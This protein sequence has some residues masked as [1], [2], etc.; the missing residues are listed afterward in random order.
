MVKKLFVLL[1]A[2][3]APELEDHVALIESERILAVRATPA[4]VRPGETVTVDALFV[5][6]NGTRADA[7]AWSLCLD[8]KPLAEPGTIA[9]S[10][11]SSGTAVA[12]TFVIPADACRQFGPER[13]EPKPGEPSGRPSDPDATGGYYQPIRVNAGSSVAFAEIRIR[14]GLAGATQEQT[15]EFAARSKPNENPRIAAF[16]APITVAR[17]QSIPIRVAWEST[18]TY[19]YFDPVARM[20]VDRR[21]AMRVSWYANAGTLASERTAR[22]TDDRALDSVNTWTAPNE[23]RD[24]VLW[25]VVRDDRGGVDYRSVRLSVQ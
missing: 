8:R 1:L 3:C 14:C 25:V 13:P 21:E 6:P 11:L 7:I 24:V 4:E 18:E 20:I 5:D 22:A 2:G 15:A 10:C 19:P 23:A 9:E 17:G 12:T 16:D